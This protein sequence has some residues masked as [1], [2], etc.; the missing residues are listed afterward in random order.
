MIFIFQRYRTPP[1]SSPDETLN[2]SRRFSPPLVARSRSPRRRT[3]SPMRSARSPFRQSRSSR[4]GSRSPR[5]RSNSP[6]RRPMSSR[7]RSKSPQKQSNSS[8]RRSLSPQR[9][10]M[11]S[12]RRSTSPRK[13]S[14]SPQRCSPSPRRHSG[15]PR[16]HSKSPQSQLLQ[17]IDS[18]QHMKDRELAEG[19][20]KQS[21]SGKDGKSSDQCATVETRGERNSNDEKANECSP[22]IE[23]RFSERRREEEGKTFSN[24]GYARS[25]FASI[26][27]TGRHRRGEKTSSDSDSEE[28][29]Q[30]SRDI[31]YR[32]EKQSHLAHKEDIRDIRKPSSYSNADEQTWRSLA[33]DYEFEEDHGTLE[34]QSCAPIPL[35]KERENN[36]ERLQSR[37]KNNDEQIPPNEESAGS[38]QEDKRA[39]LQGEGRFKHQGISERKTGRR[40][41]SRSFDRRRSSSQESDR[42]RKSRHHHR[43]HHHRHHHHRHHHKRDARQS[44]RNIVVTEKDQDISSD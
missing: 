2:I 5:R 17:R 30:E 35:S 18:K 13:H 43:R 3:R 12:R 4:E 34:A 27:E 20:M 7:R 37:G 24:E 36:R 40:Q 38:E 16:R 6:R 25:K 14:N 22:T 28:F 15:S 8:Q 23:E 9:P 41:R 42:N 33:R 32:L 26:N 31:L 11:S 39:F 21:Y 10:P 1:P 44:E 29:Q 19:I